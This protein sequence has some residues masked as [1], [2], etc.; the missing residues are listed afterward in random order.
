MFVLG[1]VLDAARLGLQR[2]PCH[3]VSPFLCALQR[4]SAGLALRLFAFL[5]RMLL[6]PSFKSD[7]QLI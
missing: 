2:Q 6:E 7:C 3:D 1:L 4:Y 5:V